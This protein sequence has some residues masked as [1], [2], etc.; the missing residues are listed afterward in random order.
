MPYAYEIATIIQ[1][2]LMLATGTYETA[3]T[4][5]SIMNDPSAQV[6]E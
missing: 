6:I 1:I 5:A 2:Y 4:T 3:N